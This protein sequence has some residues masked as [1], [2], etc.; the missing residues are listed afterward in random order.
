[1]WADV[2]LHPTMSE[3]SNLRPGLP[4]KSLLIRGSCANM[5]SSNGKR[6]KTRRCF[7]NQS[8]A[9]C[10]IT[11]DTISLHALIME[12]ADVEEDIYTQGKMYL[13]SLKTKFPFSFC[14]MVKYHVLLFQHQESAAAAA[15]TYKTWSMCRQDVHTMMHQT[16]TGRSLMISQGRKLKAP[17]Q[18]CLNLNVKYLERGSKPLQGPKRWDETFSNYCENSLTGA[19]LWPFLRIMKF[20]YSTLYNCATKGKKRFNLIRFAPT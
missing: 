18:T 17:V 4:E 16:A 11:P 15:C 14:K 3:N 7:I 5:V 2:I 20:K 12:L 10:S 8:R 6:P 9:G 13:T 19:E 1:M